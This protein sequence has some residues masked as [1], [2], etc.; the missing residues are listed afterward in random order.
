M[1]EHARPD[2]DNYININW[3]NIDEKHRRNF[4]L[5]PKLLGDLYSDE[6][7][8]Y[9]SI[10]HYSSSM[11]SV[12]PKLPTITPKGSEVAINELGYHLEN[13][14]LS[15]DDINKICKLYQCNRVSNQSNYLRA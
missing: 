5:L 8:D 1:H 15:P 11:W 7:Y 12:D 2:R 4:K 3:S 9:K 13:K 6:P 10:M 14:S